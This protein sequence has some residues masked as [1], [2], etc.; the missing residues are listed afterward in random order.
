MKGFHRGAVKYSDNGWKDVPNARNRY[1]DAGDRHFD[2]YLQGKEVY[3]PE[4]GVHHL[5]AAV[6][7]LLAVLELELTKNDKD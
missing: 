4:S 2:K 6:W 5:G 7:N 1:L 3:D